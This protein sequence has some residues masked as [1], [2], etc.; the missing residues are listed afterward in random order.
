[1]GIKQRLLAYLFLLSQKRKSVDGYEKD[2]FSYRFQEYFNLAIWKVV[3]ALRLPP[4]LFLTT[5]TVLVSPPSPTFIITLL[6]TSFKSHSTLPY[7]P[8]AFP[9]LFRILLQT[10]CG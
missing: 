1:M 7:R 2:N 5:Y 3:S 9:Q 10:E 6:L 8:Y 4:P